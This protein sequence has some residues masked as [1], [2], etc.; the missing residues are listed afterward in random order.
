[1]VAPEGVEVPMTRLLLI[2]DSPTVR[3]ATAAALELEGM[4]V[5]LAATVAEG[6]ALAEAERP[7]V[8][9][10]DVVMERAGARGIGGGGLQALQRLKAD[11]RTRRIPVVMWTGAPRERTERTVR[12]LGAVA[13][14]TK[15]AV[16]S[17]LAAALRQIARRGR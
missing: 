7:D 8:I 6:L 17:A 2:D 5:L 9:L 16:T 3:V 11:P 15:G 1:M 10:L 13:L 4:T 14:V 12:E